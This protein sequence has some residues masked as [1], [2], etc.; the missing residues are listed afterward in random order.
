ME[1]TFGGGIW[2]LEGRA[3]AYLVPGAKGAWD[4]GQQPLWSSQEAVLILVSKA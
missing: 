2:L 4:L 3:L 1:S